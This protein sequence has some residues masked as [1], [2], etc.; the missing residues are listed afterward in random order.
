MKTLSLPKLHY[1]T[2]KDDFR[3]AMQYIKV[4]NGKAM[5]TDAHI[6]AVVD[7]SC[8]DLEL[9]NCYILARDWKK[10]C[11]NN[12]IFKI[13]GNIVEIHTKAGVDLIRFIPEIEFTHKYP[14]LLSVIPTKENALPVEW[15]GLNTW[16]LSRLCAVL[17]G[18]GLKF[19]FSGINKP[20]RFDAHNSIVDIYGAIMPIYI[21]ES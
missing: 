15:I 20:I 1:I 17:P 16:V 11:A 3:P 8:F 13:V 19:Q 18:L 2:A 12:A 21:H 7:L 5:A 9:P 10:M 14:E 6:A 4:E